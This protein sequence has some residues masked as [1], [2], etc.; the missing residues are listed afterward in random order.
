MRNKICSG[1]WASAAASFAAILSGSSVSENSNTI[2]GGVEFTMQSIKDLH[3]LSSVMSMVRRITSESLITYSKHFM[4]TIE[5]LILAFWYFIILGYLGVGSFGSGDAR[6]D[7]YNYCQTR[8]IDG[9]SNLIKNKTVQNFRPIRTYVKLQKDIVQ[10]YFVFIANGSLSPKKK[11]ASLFWNR[12]SCFEDFF[13]ALIFFLTAFIQSLRYSKNQTVFFGSCL[14]YQYPPQK[15]KKQIF[16]G[17]LVIENNNKY[18]NK[19]LIIFSFKLVQF[20]HI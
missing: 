3:R 19:F 11:L 9:I 17:I 10:N 14:K 2:G 6:N 20:A 1:I 13:A 16:Y 7:L 5:M 15:K 18:P 8:S 12:I 4:R